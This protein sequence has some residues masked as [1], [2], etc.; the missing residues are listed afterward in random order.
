MWWCKHK[1]GVIYLNEDLDFQEY[2]VCL[3]IY[4]SH[5]MTN[6]LMHLY[7]RWF[8]DCCRI[9]SICL[10][11]CYLAH[12]CRGCRKWNPHNSDSNL[13]SPKRNAWGAWGHGSSNW[14]HQSP[15]QPTSVTMGLP[16]MLFGLNYALDLAF[17]ENLKYTFEFFQN[18]FMNLDGHKLNSQINGLRLTLSLV[19]AFLF[20]CCCSVRWKCFIHY[21]AL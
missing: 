5:K 2:L 14:P 19:I 17:S 11:S 18:I 16:C 21:Y 15:Q 8:C 13:H 10:C 7:F 20:L 3:C 6:W 1:E 12:W 9:C 4:F